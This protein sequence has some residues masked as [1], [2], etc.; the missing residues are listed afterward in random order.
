MTDLERKLTACPGLTAEERK[1]IAY[2]FVQARQVAADVIGYPEDEADACAVDSATPGQ[3]IVA[4]HA[5]V[6]SLKKKQQK[7]KTA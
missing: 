5:L 6:L 1:D 7:G 2:W 4:L 3:A